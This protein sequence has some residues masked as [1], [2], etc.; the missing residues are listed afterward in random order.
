MGM[1]T[2]ATL[3]ELV[4]PTDAFSLMNSCALILVSL[5]EFL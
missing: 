1:A 4:L 3:P 5:V 2:V